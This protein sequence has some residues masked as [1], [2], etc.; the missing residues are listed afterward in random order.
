MARYRIG[1]GVEFETLTPKEMH[2]YF[3]GRDQAARQRAL[4]IKFRKLP[5]MNGLVTAAGIQIGGDYPFSAA[6]N[7]V[8]QPVGPSSGHMWVIRLLAVNGLTS[9]ATPDVL[10]MQIIGGDEPDFS[11]WEFNGNNFAYA[12]GKNEMW[13]EGGDYLQFAS[14][15]AVTAAVGTRIRIRGFIQQVPT[16]LAAELI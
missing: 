9:G 12:F 14:V 16:E 3:S 15:G 2:D 10:N 11:W 13:L 5:K 8:Q 1:A 7:Q 4:G 6:G